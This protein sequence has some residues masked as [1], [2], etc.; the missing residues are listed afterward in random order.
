MHDQHGTFV[1]STLVYEG[2]YSGRHWYR[3]RI[4]KNRVTLSRL[5]EL[6]RFIELA[7]CPQ[8]TGRDPK[9]PPKPREI[10]SSCHEWSSVLST[11]SISDLRYQKQQ[12]DERPD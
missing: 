5:L 1:D 10:R 9:L 7:D 8:C 2:E 6:Y 11:E 12:R 3:C 4:C